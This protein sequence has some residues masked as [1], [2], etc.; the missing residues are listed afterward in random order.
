MVTGRMKNTNSL[1]YST[2]EIYP[3][4]PLKIEEVNEFEKK[5]HD[6]I[7]KLTTNYSDIRDCHLYLRPSEF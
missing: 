7:N 2:K 6:V 5:S 3:I 4:P 1:I